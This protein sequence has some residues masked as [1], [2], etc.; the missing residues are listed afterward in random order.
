MG[1]VSSS[2][3]ATPLSSPSSSNKKSRNNCPM[4]VESAIFGLA[5]GGD[6]PVHT[7]VSRGVRSV[8][9]GIVG[10]DI[11]R[12]KIAKSYT[13]HRGNMSSRSRTVHAIRSVIDVGLEEDKE[14]EANSKKKCFN[15]ISIFNLPNE[16]RGQPDFVGVKRENE[17]G[18]R[19]YAF[20]PFDFG[21]DNSG[22][23]ITIDG[24]EKT[25]TAKEDND[26]E[27]DYFQ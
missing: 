4:I 17:D 20:Q 23:G 18:F 26:D 3:Q 14:G 19:L 12:W 21:D 27:E 5:L 16:L 8:T 6:V 2:V 15:E 1:Y 24:K 7:I 22:I 9:S 10:S 25:D 13:F 11:S